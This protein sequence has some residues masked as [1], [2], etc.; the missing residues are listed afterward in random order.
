M[1]ILGTLLVTLLVSNGT[2]AGRVDF[3][4]KS[5]LSHQARSYLTGTLQKECPVAFQSLALRVVKEQIVPH[6][7]DQYDVE[8]F[9]L[10]DIQ[11]LSN[12]NSASAITIEFSDLKYATRPDTSDF[13]LE[14]LESTGS[15]CGASTQGP[16]SAKED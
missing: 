15:V 7:I 10:V 4:Q 9:Y 6:T 5:R 11:A 14:R 2:A 16:G 8:H 12:N 3:P 13:V 1:W